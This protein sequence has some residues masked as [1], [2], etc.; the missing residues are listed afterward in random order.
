MRF[1]ADMRLS[2]RINHNTW[3]HEKNPYGQLYH[4]SLKSSKTHRH[5]LKDSAIQLLIS[6]SGAH[7]VIQLHI[8]LLTTSERSVFSGRLESGGCVLMLVGAGNKCPFTSSA[9]PSN[10]H[11][12]TGIT[13]QHL[14]HL[15]Y[16]PF[17]SKTNIKLAPIQ[18]HKYTC[19]S[20]TD[21]KEKS[22]YKLTDKTE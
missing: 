18:I 13:G 10:F 9:N 5:T 8:F 14:Q 19:G 12:I 1:H 15:V 22:N 17:H 7:L 6:S 2:M 21:L 3:A 16:I 4:R 20:P 11:R